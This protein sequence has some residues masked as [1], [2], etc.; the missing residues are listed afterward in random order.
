MKP[1]ACV[2]YSRINLIQMTGNVVVGCNHGIEIKWI[3]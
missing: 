3:I 1:I 2:G